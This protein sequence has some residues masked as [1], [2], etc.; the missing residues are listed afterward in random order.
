MWA[1]T[2]NRT[3]ADRVGSQQ[4]PHSPAGSTPLA[5]KGNQAS[6]AGRH[7]ATGKQL[8]RANTSMLAISSSTP[9]TLKTS[10]L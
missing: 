3:K 5:V 4:Q 2:E 9:N 10:V 8:V 1:S 6:C 7:M